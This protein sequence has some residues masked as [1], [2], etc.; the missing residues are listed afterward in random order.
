MNSS[1]EGTINENYKINT[2]RKQL[3]KQQFKIIEDRFF[4][5]TIESKEP[6]NNKNNNFKSKNTKKIAYLNEINQKRV[7]NLEETL[8]NV[9]RY[10]QIANAYQIDVH[11]SNLE[12]NPQVT[13]LKSTNRLE[14]IENYIRF[15]MQAINRRNGNANRGMQKGK[16]FQKSPVGLLRLRKSFNSKLSSI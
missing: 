10:R 6:P 2:A 15:K 4:N 13:G 5:L 8:E 7:H 3:N 11:L 12:K 14:R 9:D 16:R 1:H